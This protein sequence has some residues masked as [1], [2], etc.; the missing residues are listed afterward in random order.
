MPV[1]ISSSFS[2]SKSIE[3]VY[4]KF[5]KFH[6]VIFL[7]ILTCNKTYGRHKYESF[8]KT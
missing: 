1:E 6:F 7:F 4:F 8:E 2:G 5:S 3:K